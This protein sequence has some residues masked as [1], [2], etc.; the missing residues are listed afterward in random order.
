MAKRGSR[1]AAWLFAALIASA[2][3]SGEPAAVDFSPQ[4]TIPEGRDYQDVRQRWTRH[5]Q[6]ITDAGTVLEVWATLKSPE[7][8]LGYV[9]HY[10]DTY[11]LTDE[12]RVKLREDQLRQSQ[13]VW[14]FHVDAQSTDYRWN[15]LEKRSSPWKIT[16]VDA[17]GHAL[18]P[19]S[20]EV[21]RLPEL[22]VQEF[23]PTRTDFS[24]TY[25]VKFKVP[26]AEDSAFS[27]ARSGY[28]TLRFAGPIAMTELVW[29]AR[30]GSEP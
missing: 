15:D 5:A 20:V 22:Y 24:R 14:E 1:G 27:G 10:A 12:D 30:S 17:A 6:I 8:R 9:E 25:V 3:R 2:C 11:R 7:F 29:R 4:V 19:L 28:V 26:T 16:L 21:P 23:F 18:S 13:E